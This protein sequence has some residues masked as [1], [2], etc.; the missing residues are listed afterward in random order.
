MSEKLAN[1]A[2]YS[3]AGFQRRYFDGSF[4]SN[5]LGRAHIVGKAVE[6]ALCLAF[7]PPVGKLPLPL[8]LQKPSDLGRVVFYDVLRPG[9]QAAERVT[10]NVPVSD[11]LTAIAIGEDIL[12]RFGAFPFAMEVLTVNHSAAAGEGTS[13][14]VLLQCTARTDATYAPGVYSLEIKCRAVRCFASFDWEGV[15]AHQALRLLEDEV[16][17]DNR[18]ILQGRFLVFVALPSAQVIA[19]GPVPYTSHGLFLKRGAVEGAWTRLWGWAQ[20]VRPL[21]PLLPLLRS[22]PLAP[23]ASELGGAQEASQR[24]R[25]KRSFPSASSSAAPRPAAMAE[26]ESFGN[27]GGAAAGAKPLTRTENQRWGAFQMKLEFQGAWLTMPS[28]LRAVGES[29]KHGERYVV[30]QLVDGRAPT[31]LWRG[32]RGSIPVEGRDWKYMRPKR[33][34]GGPKGTL[35]LSSAF[36]KK[37]VFQRYA[38]KAR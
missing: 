28:F 14:D 21:G 17:A 38:K 27:A 13:H 15:L 29:V 5:P 16:A 36:A 19:D 26:P 25:L 22:A 9:H 11:A 37:V 30:D 10:V 34:G 6:D 7:R 35:F 31:Q 20:S 8:A 23:P 1:I 33:G 32:A 18:G 12:R 4:G 24:R 3:A 2:D